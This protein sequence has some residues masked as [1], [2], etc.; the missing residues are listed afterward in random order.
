MQFVY[1]MATDIGPRNSQQDRMFAAPHRLVLADGMG[2]PSGGAEAAEIAVAA[3]CA[4]STLAEGFS[5]AQRE[6]LRFQRESR[7]REAGTTAVAASLTRHGLEVACCGDSRVYLVPRHGAETLLTVDQTIAGEMLR[8][9]HLTMGQFLAGE[10]HQ[11][12]LG[13]IGGNAHFRVDF[14][15]AQ[16][17]P[18]DVLVLVSDGIYRSVRPGGMAAAVRAS[19]DPAGMARSVLDLARAATLVD[20]ASVVAGLIR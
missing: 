9:G 2:G 3:I 16:V 19:R 12:L 20:N 14:S 8:N 15:T 6:V 18:G 10:G 7:H 1:S 4:S 5:V 13:A 11:G 17:E